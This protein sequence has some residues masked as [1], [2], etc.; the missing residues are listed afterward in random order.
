MAE[1]VKAKEE[2]KD[3]NIKA[4]HEMMTKILGWGTVIYLIV[5]GYSFDQHAMFEYCPNKK[6]EIV[7]QEKKD[8]AEE[9]RKK[10]NS[11]KESGNDLEASEFSVKA[12][13]SDLEAKISE[14]DIKDGSVRA[15]SLVL[16]VSGFFILY[17]SLVFMFYRKYKSEML[18]YVFPERAA[19]IYVALVGTITLVLAILIGR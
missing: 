12:A 9:L 8:R 19:L 10:S 7:I 11:L 2:N 14:D 13:E 6:Q 18:S 3:D 17:F 16:G 5:L 15:V 1:N 4:K